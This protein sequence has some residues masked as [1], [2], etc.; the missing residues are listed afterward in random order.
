MK[1]EY[2]SQLGCF[3]RSD[4]LGKKIWVTM[5]EAQRIVT[6]RDLGNSIGEIQ[7]KMSFVSS[8]ATSYSVKTILA[9]YDDGSINIDM[10]VPAPDIQFKDM[11]IE[12]RISDLEKRLSKLEESF[13]S[14][15]W[16]DKT[17]FM[18]KVKLWVR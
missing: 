14:I 18:E 6:L 1:Y 17:S 7:A 9:K 11:G 4:G 2:N 5:T 3:E 15:E 10:S 16:E 13:N 8:K 12:E